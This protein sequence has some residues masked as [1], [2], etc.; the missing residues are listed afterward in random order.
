MSN[1]Q[2][3]PSPDESKKEKD[4]GHKKGGNRYNNKA[5]HPTP[6]LTKFEGKCDELK[7]HIYDCSHAKQADQFTKTT[8]E[9][10]EYVGRTYKHG[11]DI[12]LD[13]NNW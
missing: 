11:G 6:K 3:R 13:R 7:G 12:R 10:S 4:H 5:I 9:I 1:D 2:A 8:K